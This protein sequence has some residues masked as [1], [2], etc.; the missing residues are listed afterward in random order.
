MR[1]FSVTEAR[2]KLA[3]VLDLAKTEDV[4]I[5]R[6]GGEKFLLSLQRERRSPFDVASVT[7]HDITTDEI[8]EVIRE[9]RERPWLDAPQDKRPTSVKKKQAGRKAK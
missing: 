8:V 6:R 2:Q 5:H 9:M 1:V 4:I 3:E 7:D